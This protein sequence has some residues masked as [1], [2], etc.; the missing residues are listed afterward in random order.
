MNALRESYGQEIDQILAK[1]PDDEK[2]SAVMPLL[3]VAMR[4]DGY[5]NK[6]DLE[7]IGEIIG[8]SSTDV[9]S[10][11]GFYTLFHDKPEGKYRIQ[12]CNDL[13]CALRGADEY[14]DNLCDNLGIR[15]GETTEDG[16]V[17]LEAVMC[18]AA[19]D[20]APMFQ[21]QDYNGVAYHENQTVESTMQLVESWR[22][23]GGKD[24]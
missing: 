14:L 9:A 24:A 10:I 13:P 2:R 7:D 18:L 1:Y 5:V 19:C 3:F 16:V 8:R 23:E 22:A 6:Q 21:V 12:V 11:L 17:T 15:P 20:K 4:K